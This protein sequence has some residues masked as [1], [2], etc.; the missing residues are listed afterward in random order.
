MKIY[1]ELVCSL[2]SVRASEKQ[3]QNFDQT[4]LSVDSLKKLLQLG[5]KL[6][7]YHLQKI[8]HLA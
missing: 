7:F 6:I 3:K 1:Y 4:S 2:P 8:S 5:T